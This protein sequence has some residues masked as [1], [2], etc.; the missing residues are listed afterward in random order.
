VIVEV[1]IFDRLA[2]TVVAKTGRFNKPRDAI[3]RHQFALAK[4]A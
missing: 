4:C 1:R 3:F 2:V